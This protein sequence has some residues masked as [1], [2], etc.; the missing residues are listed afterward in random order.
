MVQ[1]YL[2]KIQIANER[3]YWLGKSATKEAAFTS[4]FTGLLPTIAAASGVYKVG[5]GKPSTS[6]AATA[7]SASGI[8]TVA[9]TSSLSDGDVVTLTAVTGGISG[10][11]LKSGNGVV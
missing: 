4:P 2:T 1:R 9:D 10:S 7:T 8:V 6:I 5:L 3:L 11:L